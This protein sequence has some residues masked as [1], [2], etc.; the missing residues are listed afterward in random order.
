MKGRT[1]LASDKTQ[2]A[3]RVSRLPFRS[4]ALVTLVQDG[5]RRGRAVPRV[6]GQ[7][8]VSQRIRAV[9]WAREQLGLFKGSHSCIRADK[10]CE[11][12][13]GFNVPV[14]L[15]SPADRETC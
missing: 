7:A 9:G 13:R 2:G 4:M 1:A 8:A 6:S 15:M 3:P 5:W 14:S 12:E 11:Q 10:G